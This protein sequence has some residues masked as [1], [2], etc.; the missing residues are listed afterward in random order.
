MSLIKKGRQETGA[1]FYY[2]EH[3]SVMNFHE[4]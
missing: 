3:S 1:L 2:P 4:H